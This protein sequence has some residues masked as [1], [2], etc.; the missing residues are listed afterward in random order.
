MKKLFYTIA[1]VILLGS[2]TTVKEVPVKVNTQ[3]LPLGDTVKLYKGSIVY[4]LPLTGFEFTVVA[5]RTVQT[6]GPYHDYADQFLGLKDVI[7][8]N[9]TV[10]TLREVKIEP[11]NELD[12]EQ[13][14]VIE[15][16]GL[17][18]TNAL[19]LKA[20]GLILDINKEMYTRRSYYSKNLENNEQVK[21]AIRDMGSDEYYNI[22]QD[23]TY[24]I[25]ELD[26]AFVRIPYVLERRRQLSLEEQAE[27][28]A[29]ILLEL[30]EGRHLIL[31][32]EAN[33]FPQ[34]KAAIDEIN[35]LENEYISLFTGKATSEIRT[36]KFFFIPEKGME[37]RPVILFRFS[38]EDGVLDPTDL[39]GRPVAVEL[40]STGKVDRINLLEDNDSQSERYDRLY[41]RIPEVVDIKV[42]DGRSTLGSS[43]QLIYQFGKVV[44]L[45]ANYIIR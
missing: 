29:R 25:V 32:G 41:Y 11:F 1:V 19:A 40:F 9:N 36:F 28:T 16:D 13:Y 38:P 30:R 2:C 17:I 18:E 7:R 35:R 33:V 12:P 45:P 37:S 22:E 3:I 39:S 5:Q 27:S 21:T 23:T 15:S 43:R 34:D 31:T 44:T 42:T 14:Y 4:S 6:A 20:A 8:S 10:W 26:T 24:K